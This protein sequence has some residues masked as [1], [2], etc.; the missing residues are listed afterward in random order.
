MRR[1]KQTND[2]FFLDDYLET[3]ASTHQN[4]SKLQDALK[5]FGNENIFNEENS[6]RKTSKENRESMNI[7]AENEKDCIG[8]DV[9]EN[10]ENFEQNE[11]SENSLDGWDDEIVERNPQN[12]FKINSSINDL[13]LI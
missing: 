8:G 5:N 4:M 2:R 11:N 1:D 7:L 3:T 6:L 13:F 12:R 9:E 10:T